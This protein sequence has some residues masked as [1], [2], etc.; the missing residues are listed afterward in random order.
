MQSLDRHNVP[1][2][3]MEVFDEGERLREQ[4]KTRLKES[5]DHKAFVKKPDGETSIVASVKALDD[6]LK[7][8]GQPHQGT[9]E[10]ERRV[11]QAVRQEL[12]VK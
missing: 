12:K 4:F 9:K 10:R 2:G 11:K 8:H 6:F 3:E 1:I 7:S 5:P